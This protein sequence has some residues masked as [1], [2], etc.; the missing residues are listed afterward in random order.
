MRNAPNQMDSFNWFNAQITNHRLGTHLKGRFSASTD[1]PAKSTV[2][3]VAPR[4]EWPINPSIPARMITDFNH[5][6]MVA[7]DTGSCGLTN[8]M[9][10]GP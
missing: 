8:E 10:N 2:V 5:L 7:N 4:V 3:E 6:A 9:N 1:K